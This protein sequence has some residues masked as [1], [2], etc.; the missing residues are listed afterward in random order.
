[1]KTSEIAGRILLK[2]IKRK[3]QV[4]KEESENLEVGNFELLFLNAGSS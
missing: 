4:S 1:M 2:K 3:E